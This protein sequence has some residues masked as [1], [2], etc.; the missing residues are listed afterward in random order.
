ME[1]GDE[2]MEELDYRAEGCEFF[3]FFGNVCFTH[4]HVGAVEA[5]TGSAKTGSINIHSW[6]GERFI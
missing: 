6:M 4:E 2:R 5:F 3:F 1:E